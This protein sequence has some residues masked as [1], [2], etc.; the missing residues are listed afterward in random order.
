MCTLG[1]GLRRSM[2]V[3]AH[4]NLLALAIVSIYNLNILSSPQWQL[5]G[6]V[7]AGLSG[8]NHKLVGIALNS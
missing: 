3:R 8:D 4:V 6:S 7:Y 2:H 1:N 5:E